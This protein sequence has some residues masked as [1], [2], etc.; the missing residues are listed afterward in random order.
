MIFLYLL[1]SN[2]SQI[3]KPI[4]NAT[5]SPRIAV[6]VE[7]FMIKINSHNPKKRQNILLA[8]FF[9]AKKRSKIKAS[10][11]RAEYLR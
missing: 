1:F 5:K 11:S 7:N 3:K 2:I 9:K 4:V 8:H 6:S 10:E